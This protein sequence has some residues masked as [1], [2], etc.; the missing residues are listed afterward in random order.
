MAATHPAKHSVPGKVLCSE[1]SPNQ[2]LSKFS[3]E[4]RQDPLERAIHLPGIPN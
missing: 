4:E 3:E 1:A 2:F